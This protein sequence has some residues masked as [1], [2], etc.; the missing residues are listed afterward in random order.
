MLRAFRAS[1]A[2]L[3][4]SNFKERIKMR[5]AVVYDSVFISSNS[6]FLR[7]IYSHSV[8]SFLCNNNYT[9][10]ITKVREKYKELNDTRIECL[11]DFCNTATCS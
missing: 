10:R 5:C 7:V 2:I 11:L 3:H 8:A 9:Y 6:I 1:W 4:F